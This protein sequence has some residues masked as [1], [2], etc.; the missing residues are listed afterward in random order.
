MKSKRVLDLFKKNRLLADLPTYAH[1]DTDCADT[2]PKNST[3]LRHA[4][5]HR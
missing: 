1:K 3:R 5:E 2:A 4:C